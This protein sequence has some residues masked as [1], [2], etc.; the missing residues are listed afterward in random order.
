M[1]DMLATFDGRHGLGSLGFCQL[2]FRGFGSAVCSQ[3]ALLCW[4]AR[5]LTFFVARLQ[6]ALAVSLSALDV[7]LLLCLLCLHI[8]RVVL[9]VA[10]NVLQHSVAAQTLRN[11]GDLL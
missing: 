9:C 10:C 11:S 3:S 6:R 4:P 2:G 1:G 7:V 5:G 8:H